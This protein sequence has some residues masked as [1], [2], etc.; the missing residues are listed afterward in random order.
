MTFP[1]RLSCVAF[2]LF[3][4]GPFPVGASP[5]Q[6]D[7]LTLYNEAA[8][9]WPGQPA[10]Q[11]PRV[12]SQI[13]RRGV[14]VAPVK[15]FGG[16]YFIDSSVVA[17]S[18]VEDTVVSFATEKDWNNFLA[19][20]PKHIS[21]VSCCPRS[22]IDNSCGNAQ[23]VL[24]TDR[25]GAIKSLAFS[26]AMIDVYQCKE[27]ALGQASWVRIGEQKFGRCLNKAAGEASKKAK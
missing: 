19:A 11:K 21:V 14:A 17:D 5:L 16:C 18:S 25:V 26:S 27:T 23:K 6:S 13:V 12:T 3:L 1:L 2:A 22:V 20:H 9:S 15:P 4:V 7:N 8:V 10:S 24:P